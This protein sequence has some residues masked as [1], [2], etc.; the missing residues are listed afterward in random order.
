MG[1]VLSTLDRLRAVREVVD[2][3]RELL[4][5]A[6]GE[7]ARLRELT[8]LFERCEPFRLAAASAAI[9]VVVAA[10]YL[11]RRRIVAGRAVELTAILGEAAAHAAGT[12]LIGPAWFLV[13][14]TVRALRADRF[15]RAARN[16]GVLAVLQAHPW[17]LQWAFPE[18][19][20]EEPGVLDLLLGLLTH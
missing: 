3:A 14:W 17:V 15:G 19:P 18:P 8:L 10:D 4:R 20:E 2:Q 1:S 12:L 5:G 6:E 9:L 13:V 16:L 11:L 7:L